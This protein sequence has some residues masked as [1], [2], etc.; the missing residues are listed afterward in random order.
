LS[1]VRRF[2]QGEIGGHGLA[3]QRSLCGKRVSRI[4]SKRASPGGLFRLGDTAIGLA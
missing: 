4:G 1:F 3:E 2:A